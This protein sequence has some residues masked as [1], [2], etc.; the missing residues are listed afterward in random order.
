MHTRCEHEEHS[1]EMD[2]ELTG[3]QTASVFSL[4]L[5]LFSSG[6]GTRGTLHCSEALT[7]SRLSGLSGLCGRCGGGLH[8]AESHMATGPVAVVRAAWLMAGRSRVEV[9]LELMV[10]WGSLATPHCSASGNWHYSCYSGN[11]RGP[12]T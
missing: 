11:R 4:S 1:I 7:A 8:P 2:A 6:C 3:W 10:T 5:Y 9:G 12:D